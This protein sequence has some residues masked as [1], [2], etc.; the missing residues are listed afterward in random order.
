MSGEVREGSYDGSGALGS[1][2]YE[3]VT[4]E[5]LASTPGS[6]QRRVLFEGSPGSGDHTPALSPRLGADSPFGG[7]Q[8]RLSQLGE[9]GKGKGLETGESAMSLEERDPVTG[10]ME[11]E[12]ESRGGSLS[13]S[14]DLESFKERVESR[15]SP[16]EK[17]KGS[18]WKG[19]KD[20]MSSN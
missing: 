7:A 6:S 11:Q 13:H 19:F 15:A 16:G 3:Q 2:A 1:G 14:V 8:L 20:W 9:T 10:L 17:K 5:D 18:K 4:Y 12:L